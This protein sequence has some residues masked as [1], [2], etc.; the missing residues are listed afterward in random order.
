MVD[1]INSRPHDPS[2]FTSH[3]HAHLIMKLTKGPFVEL[4]TCLDVVVLK[5]YSR[6]KGK[7]GQ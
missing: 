2:L 4:Q 6:T 5:K 7:R 3:I 1:E